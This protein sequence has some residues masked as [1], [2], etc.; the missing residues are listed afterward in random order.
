MLTVGVSLQL[1][2]KTIPNNS[3][4]DLEEFL[5]NP[6]QEPTNANGL[7][8]LTCVTDR[9]ECCETSALGSW[10]YPNGSTIDQLDDGETDPIFQSNS[11][12]NEV[13]NGRQFYGSVRLWRRWTPPERGLFRCELPD[14]DG[15]NQS[16]YVNI[17]EFPIIIISFVLQCMGASKAP[18]SDY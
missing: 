4:V 2:G 15:V 16:L 11:G 6:P 10:Y 9:V 5:Y 14:A 1:N 17:C 13:I 18:P 7:Q 12:Q 3:L 8:T